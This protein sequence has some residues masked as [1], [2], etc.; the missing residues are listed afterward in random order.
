MLTD[1]YSV[2]YERTHANK[3]GYG[4]DDRTPAMRFCSS[5]CKK[6]GG[7]AIFLTR[8]NIL[9]FLPRNLFLCLVFHNNS[10]AFH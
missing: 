10:P 5:S 4:T 6:R 1:Y 9:I 8:L 7:D 3:N 2:E